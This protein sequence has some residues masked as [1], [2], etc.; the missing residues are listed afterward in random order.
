MRICAR[1]RESGVT[2]SANPAGMKCLQPPVATGGT[3]HKNAQTPK[4]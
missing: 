1:L 4:E 2:S 3:H